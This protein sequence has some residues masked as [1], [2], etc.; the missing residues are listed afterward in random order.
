MEDI[1]LATGTTLDCAAQLFGLKRQ[2]WEWDESLRLRIIDAY[3]KHISLRP[4]MEIKKPECECGKDKHNFANHSNW[5][6][7]FT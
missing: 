7:L 4:V 3:N 2:S 6:P 5:C 1:E